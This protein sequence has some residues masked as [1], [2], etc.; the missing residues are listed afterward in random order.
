LQ[1]TPDPVVITPATAE[2]VAAALRNA[3]ERRHSLVIRGAGTK[4]DWGRPGSF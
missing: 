3:S 1:S 2:E 4:S